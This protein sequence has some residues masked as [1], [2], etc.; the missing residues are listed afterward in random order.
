MF[1]TIRSI[2]SL[3]LMELSLWVAPEG[4]KSSAALA[5]NQHAK[6]TLFT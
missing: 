2:L 6:R 5:I 3:W 1:T 4:E